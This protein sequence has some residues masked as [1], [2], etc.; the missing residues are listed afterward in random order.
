MLETAVLNS[1][2]LFN[3]ELYQ[4]TDGVGMGLPLGPTFANICLCY[5]EQKWLQNCPLEIRPAYYKRYVDDCFLIFNDGSHVDSFLAYLNGQ[6]PKIRFTKEIEQNGCLSFLDICLRRQTD[7]LELSVY[8]KQTFTGL[9]LSFFSFI[10]F[11]IKKAVVHSAVYRAFRLS[12]TYKS[13]DNELNF[14][15]N[16][17]RI[18]GFPKYLIESVIKCVLDKLFSP[19]IDTPPSVAKL[20]KYIVLPYFGAKSINLKKDVVDLL[21]KY[22]PYLNLKV[23][24]RN[25]FTISSLFHFKDRIPKCLRSGIVYKF[26][27]SSCEESYIGS[28]Y[29]RLYSRVCEHKGVSDRN[30][31]MLLSPKNSSIRD[32]SHQ[33]D[34][35]F[36]IK[37][38]TILDSEPTHSSLRLLESLYIHK[39]RPKINGNSSSYPLCVVR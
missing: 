5:H 31:T 3:K 29:V 20:E 17:F 11:S 37:D 33:C 13:F 27:C 1:Y 10:P 2:F 19:K 35:P 15:R 4:Q 21:A 38:F 6:H 25:R 16:F 23:V 32:H 24:L 8:R 28:T 34:T 7:K 26:S 18:N 12:S 14:I 39:H 36:S 30:Q 9:G 22:Y